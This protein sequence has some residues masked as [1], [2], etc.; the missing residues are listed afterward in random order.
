MLRAATQ[1]LQ[2]V[3]RATALLPSVTS[4]RLMSHHEETAEEFDNRYVSYLSRPD[5][6]GWEVRKAMNDLQGYDCVPE[7]KIVIAAMKACRK[8]NDYALAVRYL[9]AVKDKCGPKVGEIWPY[10]MKEIGPTLKELGI[11]TL[12]EMGY[13]KPELACQDVFSM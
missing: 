3:L 5:I 8:V 11:S 13:D 2:L 12:E 1:R 7:P 9:E 6:D 4:V 10:M